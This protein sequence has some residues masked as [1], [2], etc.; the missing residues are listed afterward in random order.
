MQKADS[1]YTSRELKVFKNCSLRAKNNILTL[2][3]I[4]ECQVASNFAN[5]ICNFNLPKTIEENVKNHL[6]NH[7]FEILIN[8]K[9]NH[10]KFEGIDGNGWHHYVFGEQNLVISI[11]NIEKYGWNCFQDR[12]KRMG[13]GVHVQPAKKVK[14]L[15]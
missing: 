2:Q 1:E 11:V 8:G 13:T 14:T 3:E 4:A 10:G 15:T 7:H 9:E 5:S 6:H 12:R